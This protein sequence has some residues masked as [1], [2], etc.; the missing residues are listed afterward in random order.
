MRRQAGRAVT[1]TIIG[2]CAASAAIGG[3]PARVAPPA[4]IRAIASDARLGPAVPVLDHRLRLDDP[5]GQVRHGFG[6]TLVDLFPFESSRF[7]LSA[8]G[9][10]FGRPRANRALDERGLLATPR[11]GGGGMRSGGRRFAPALLMG[12]GEAAGGGVELGVDAGVVMGPAMERG[13]RMPR[14]ARLGGSDR[15]APHGPNGIARMTVE[16]R[17]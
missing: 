17:F 11:A 16:Y 10:L 7:H 8:G 5:A 15:G 2:C 14:G 9:R 4:H 6:G 3:E 1:T 12:I 13:A